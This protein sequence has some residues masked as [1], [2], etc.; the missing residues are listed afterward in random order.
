MS[1]ELIPEI[2]LEPFKVSSALQAA[3]T[4][5]T[6]A[7]ESRSFSD[8]HPELGKM[9]NCRVCSTRH[10]VNE[11]KCE[12]KFTYTIG[13]YEHFVENEAGELVP[14]YRTV[15]R[16]GERP[17][18]K[19]TLGQAAFVKKR[20]NKHP[21]KI[22]LQLIERTRR[23]FLELGFD[24]DETAEVFQKNLQRA[25]VIAAREIRAERELKDRAARRR[26]DVSRRINR[27]LLAR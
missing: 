13:D 24:L 8:R 26:A 1:D 5:A 12:Q 4:D 15:P 19:Q 22:K 21:S 10:R 7:I 16:A 9:V 2:R 18:M 11:R 27:G 25:K 20:F 17:T 6:T 3:L 23:V 14:D